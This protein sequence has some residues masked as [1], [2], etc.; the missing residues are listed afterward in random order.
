MRSSFR[1]LL[2]PVATRAG[3]THVLIKNYGKG[4]AISVLLYEPPVRGTSEPIGETDVIEP[5]STPR[6][7][8]TPTRCRRVSHGYDVLDA[9]LT[10]SS[11]K[12]FAWSRRPA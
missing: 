5:L 4:P 11:S 12:P 7:S 6:S 8:A 2:R 3:V 9:R 1:P 10:G